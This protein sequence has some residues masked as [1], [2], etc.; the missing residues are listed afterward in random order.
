MV[1]NKNAKKDGNS[2]LKPEWKEM[3][4]V[5]TCTSIRHHQGNFKANLFIYLIYIPLFSPMRAQGDS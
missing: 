2:Y 5:D 1:T 4:L 3:L